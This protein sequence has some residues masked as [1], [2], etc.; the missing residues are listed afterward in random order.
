MEDPTT[1]NEC[2]S[3]ERRLP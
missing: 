3:N 1:G 2:W